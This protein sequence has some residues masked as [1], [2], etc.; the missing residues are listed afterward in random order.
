MHIQNEKDKLD[1]HNTERK[2]DLCLCLTYHH[3][4]QV[5]HKNNRQRRMREIKYSKKCMALYFQTF[6]IGW[7]WYQAKESKRIIRTTD[8]ANK[9]KKSSYEM[10]ESMIFV[11]SVC[12]VFLVDNEMF[13][14]PIDRFS[15][16]RSLETETTTTTTTVFNFFC[17]CLKILLFPKN[18]A[19]ISISH[20]NLKS[21]PICVRIVQVLKQKRSQF[22][23]L[24]KKQTCQNYIQFLFKSGELS[25]IVSW[26]SLI[27]LGCS[28]RVC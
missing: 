3:W 27:E 7:K 5:K 18:D 11:C 24:K 6:F 1:K 8:V 23:M 17:D 26:G 21:I 25:R 28:W 12:E 4:Y 15:T 2:T 19:S 20:T 9:R 10:I 14:W 16:S 22:Q 13:I